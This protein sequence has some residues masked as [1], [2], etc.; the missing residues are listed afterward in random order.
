M[1]QEVIFASSHAIIVSDPLGYVSE[2]MVR[3]GNPKPGMTSTKIILVII[4]LAAV[5]ILDAFLASAMFAGRSRETLK[6]LLFV[7]GVVLVLVG[8]LR[9]VRGADTPM[10][11]FIALSQGVA[12]RRDPLRQGYA[13]KKISAGQLAVYLFLVIVGMALIGLAFVIH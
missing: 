2:K 11:V 5:L 8:S 12:S 13:G 4:V 6:T 7:E 3:K 9:A 10:D 1:A